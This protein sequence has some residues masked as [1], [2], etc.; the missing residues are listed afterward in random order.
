MHEQWYADKRDLVKWGSIVFLA[1]QCQ[2]SRIIQV[3]FSH[4]DTQ[5]WEKCRLLKNKKTEVPFP[6]EV[7]DHFRSLE[8]SKGLGRL[9]GIPIEVFCWSWKNNARD[10]YV[11]KLIE[12]LGNFAGSSLV[13]LDPDTGMEPQE[14][15]LRHVK[16]SEIK[17]IFEALKSGDCLVLYQHRRRTNNWRKETLGSFASAIG[18]PRRMVQSMWYNGKS[19]AFAK[20]VAFYFVQKR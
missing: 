17:T 7:W 12:F 10:Q 19:S 2:T 3:P 4:G 8:G 20:D 14:A 16:K 5:P 1:R 13:F 18:V 15:S 6:R 9:I 11:S